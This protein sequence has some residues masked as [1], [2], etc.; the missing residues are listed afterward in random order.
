MVSAFIKRMRSR[1]KVKEK[2]MRGVF[3]KRYSIVAAALFFA[4][5]TGCAGSKTDEGAGE[6]VDSSTMT[7]KIKTKLLT[8]KRVEGLGINVDTFEDT[9]QLSGFVRS[10]SERERAGLLAAQVAGVREVVNNLEVKAE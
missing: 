1:K 2:Q 4:F 9:V 5:F 6:M 10:E 8:D 3:M 7:T